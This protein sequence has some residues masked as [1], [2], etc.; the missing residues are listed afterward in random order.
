MYNIGCMI[1]QL[2][3]LPFEVIRITGSTLYYIIDFT[4]W[5]YMDPLKNLIL[6][7][8]EYLNVHVIDK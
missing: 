4:Q 1:S 8:G 2:N 6:E 7:E 5:L 3:L